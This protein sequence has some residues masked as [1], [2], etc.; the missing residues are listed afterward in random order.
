MLFLIFGR[1]IMKNNYMIFASMYRYMQ[2]YRVMI[3]KTRLENELLSMEITNRVT[4]KAM[5]KKGLK[6]NYDIKDGKTALSCIEDLDS[7]R[8]VLSPAMSFMIQIYLEHEENF[9][10]LTSNFVN[11]NYLSE[12]NILNTVQLYNAAGTIELSEED[13][14]KLVEDVR[15]HVSRFFKKRKKQLRQLNKFFQQ[16]ESLLPFAKNV[17]FLAF[18][19]ARMVDII[20][21][22]V[23]VGYL[24]V[25]DAVPLLD[26]IGS[27]IIH[28]YKNWEIFLASAILGKQFMLFD[29][30]VKSPFIKGSDEYISDIY[31]LVT[32]PNKPLLI[33]GIWENSN[34]VEFTKVLEEYI[35]IDEELQLRNEVEKFN[36]LR[37]ETIIKGGGSLDKEAQAIELFEELFLRKARE[38]GV[39]SYFEVSPISRNMHTALDDLDGSR[40]FWHSIQSLK[41]SFEEGEIPFLYTKAMVFTNKNI[42]KIKKRLFRK[43]VDK[44]SWDLPIEFTFHVSKI[45]EIILKVNGEQ[46]GY[47]NLDCKDRDISPME[48]CSMDIKEAEE[49]LLDDLHK[50]NS[51]FSSFKDKL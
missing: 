14:N 7:N 41:I 42:Y 45:G 33:S 12:E 24:E 22:S 3:P 51:I 46:I 36:T 8:Y 37:E 19:S 40:W 38:I 5:I 49:F 21:K 20:G 29:S 34:L 17:G 9:V 43:T 35:D 44:L 25:E 15:N 10:A 6:S 23:N 2:D 26:E 18:D 13:K 1:T 16:F 11:E 27:Y 48:F 47:T 50:L 39:A 31:G 28:T 4:G 32:S 30:G